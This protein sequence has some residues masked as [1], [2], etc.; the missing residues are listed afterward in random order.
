MEIFVSPDPATRGE[1]IH[2]KV[3]GAGPGE[4]VTLKLTDMEGHESSVVI[5]LDGG[6]GGANWTVPGDWGSSIFIT[7]PNGESVTVGVQ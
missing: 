3:S 7:G 2:I 5:E 1:D 4:S 6:A